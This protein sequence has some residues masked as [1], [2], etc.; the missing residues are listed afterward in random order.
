MK[1]IVML[2]ALAALTIAPAAV[3]SDAWIHIDIKDDSDGDDEIVK[4]NIPLSM[5]ER[6][7]PALQDEHL[8]NGK[9]KFDFDHDNDDEDTDDGQAR[10]RGL[11][12]TAREIDIKA[13]MR[14]LRDTPD[15]DFVRIRDREDNVS[16]SKSG[17][18]ILVNVDSRSDRNEKV[19]VRMPLDIADAIAQ[20]DDDELDLVALMRSLSRHSGEDLITVEDGETHIRIWIDSKMESR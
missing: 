11:K 2:A 9:L 18:Y 14:A 10:D 1:P 19:R 4:L 6:M 7:L 17:D 16:V 5:V 20:G 13:V 15:G 12:R 3:A 8:R